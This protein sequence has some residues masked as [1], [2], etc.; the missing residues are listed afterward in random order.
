MVNVGITKI[1][2]I[3]LGSLSCANWILAYRQYGGNRIIKRRSCNF[4]RRRLPFGNPRYSNSNAPTS[5]PHLQGYQKFIIHP[6]HENRFPS[7]GRLF[8]SRY[9]DKYAHLVPFVFTLLQHIYAFYPARVRVISALRAFYSLSIFTYTFVIRIILHSDYFVPQNIRPIAKWKSEHFCLV[10]N[11]NCCCHAYKALQDNLLR[12]KVTRV[13]DI[14]VGS[15]WASWDVSLSIRV[16]VVCC[17]EFWSMPRPPGGTYVHHARKKKRS[18]AAFPINARASIYL[19]HIIL[20]EIKAGQTFHVVTCF[21]G[22]N[23]NKYDKLQNC[24]LPKELL[25]HFSISSF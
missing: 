21:N 24:N 8:R 3:R 18:E 7:R 5:E 16:A 11:C 6:T 22:I 23:E 25:L 19:K 20:L 9:F 2:V 12:D 15:I 4:E 10:I 17:R 1:H 14:V 13:Y